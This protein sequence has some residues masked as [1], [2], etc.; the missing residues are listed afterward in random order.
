MNY[1]LATTTWDDKEYA[2]IAEVV[3]EGMFTM[4]R[5]VRAFEEAFATWVGSRHAVMVNS[6]SSANLVAIAALCYRK[7]NPLQRG[8][9]VIVPAVSWATTYTPLTQYGLNIRFVDIDPLTLNMDLGQL[10]EAI[11]P[12]TRL[13]V[14]VNL[15][16]NP[17]DFDRINSIIAG[18]GIELFEDNC[19][20]MGAVYEGRPAGTF[21]C[22]GTFSCFF[23]HH[24]STMEGGMVV[25]DDLE[26]YQLLL[27][28]R[29]HG[30]T[31]QLPKDNLICGA[32]DDDPFNEA[33][34]FV[35]PGYNLRPLEMSGALGLSQLS[36]LPSFVQ[37]RR[38]NAKSF[39]DLF[40]NHPQIRIQHEIGESSWFSLALVRREDAKFTREQLVTALRANGIECRPIV[41]GNFLRNPVIR[42]MPHTVH[43]TLPAANWIHDH[44]LY[45]GNHHYDLSDELGRVRQVVDSLD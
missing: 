41:A 8:D 23:S 39:V 12:R 14:A 11:T 6:G 9:E 22:M 25:T 3:K 27:S 16:G 37:G 34:R 26:L 33:F 1:P 40:G 36:K 44:G 35:L 43:G 5:R 28:L 30:W 13:V 42:H 17:N 10:E 4:G 18:K 32:L 45:I 29:A 19:E 20:S 21:G 31:R 7:E 15:L 2:A 24:I 38:K